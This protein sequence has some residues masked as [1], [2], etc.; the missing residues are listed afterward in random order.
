MN[1]VEELLDC[2]KLTALNVMYTSDQK[3]EEE[4][5]EEE[6]ETQVSIQLAAGRN[7]P[8]MHSKQVA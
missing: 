1:K 8:C 2:V 6:G 5:G 4:G 7:V 3:T